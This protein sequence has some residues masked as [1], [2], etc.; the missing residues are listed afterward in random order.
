MLLSHATGDGICPNFLRVYDVFL[1]PDQPRPDL[2]GNRAHRKPVKLL[3]E[4]HANPDA[5]VCEKDILVCPSNES[6]R[7]F[8]YIRMEFCDGGDLENFVGL[9]KDKTLP[10]ACVAVPFFFQ[11]VYSMY[12]ARERFNLR[13]CDIKV[14]LVWFL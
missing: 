8:Q 10:V 5:E 3:A 6:E 1:A 14:C 11:M 12:C 9:Q 2:W 13:H 7:L 4:A